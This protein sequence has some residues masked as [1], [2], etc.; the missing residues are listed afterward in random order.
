M[1]KVIKFRDNGE[2]E[3]IS[4]F[5]EQ[6]GLDNDSVPARILIRQGERALDEFFRLLRDVTQPLKLS[7]IDYF[8][9][10]LNI[11]LK[12]QKKAEK[13]SLTALFV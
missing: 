9:T 4:K 6:F 5:K 2:S 10:S 12:K 11:W 8:T 13:E 1:G 3:I 7:E